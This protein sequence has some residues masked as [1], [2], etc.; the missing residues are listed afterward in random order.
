MDAPLEP[1]GTRVHGVPQ[2]VILST[3]CSESLLLYLAIFFAKYIHELEQDI[4]ARPRYNP[5][6]LIFASPDKYSRV[7]HV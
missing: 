5:R 7:S 4:A 3:V 6:Q 1:T 2:E